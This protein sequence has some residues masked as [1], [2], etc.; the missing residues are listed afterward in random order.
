MATICRNLNQLYRL[1]L[2]RGFASGA[3]AATPGG[4][5][6]SLSDEQQELLDLAEKFSKEEIIPNAAHYDLVSIT[7]LYLLFKNVKCTICPSN[8]IDKY[9]AIACKS[10][11]IKIHH[12]VIVLFE[13]KA[14][15]VSRLGS[16]PGR[17][18][19]RLTKWAS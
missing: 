2:T 11:P 14:C 13:L 16:T 5:N 6:F 15:H 1:T 18:S 8:A 12:Y 19:K 7:L 4:I 10:F 3:P 17:S 9:V